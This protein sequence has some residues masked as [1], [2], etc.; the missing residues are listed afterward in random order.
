[1]DLNVACL[2]TL[3]GGALSARMIAHRAIVLLLHHGGQK[4]GNSPDPATI[5]STV[6]SSGEDGCQQQV[7]EAQG[8]NHWRHVHP[9]FHVISMIDSAYE[10]I[11]L[12]FESSH[13]GTL[14]HLNLISYPF[15]GVGA[16]ADIGKVRLRRT[17]LPS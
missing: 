10:A 17:R 16:L 12:L 7:Y 9:G 11:H 3:R 6:L 15:G 5:S 2:P 4:R 8:R 13:V 1:V 14:S